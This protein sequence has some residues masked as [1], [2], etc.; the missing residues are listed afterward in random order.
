VADGA[1]PALSGALG[2]EDSPP[3]Q[4]ELVLALLRF[5]D[6]DQARDA[7]RQALSRPQFSSVARLVIEERFL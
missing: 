6:S 2:Q 4:L 5:A 3:A 1:I 7:L